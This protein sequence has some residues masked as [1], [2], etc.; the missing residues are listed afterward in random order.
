M[1][2]IMMAL[3]QMAGGGG[4]PAPG[5]A[6][7]GMPMGGGMPMMPPGPP[8][9]P[10][11]FIPGGRPPG[12]APGGAPPPVS[13][14]GDMTGDVVQDLII[15]AQSLLQMAVQQIQ[16]MD[17]S[18]QKADM[19][20]GILRDLSGVIA[21]DQGAPFGMGPSRTPSSNAPMSHPGMNRLAGPGRARSTSDL[22]D[23][24]PPPDSGM[25]MPL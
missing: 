8:P 7:P 20:S 17:P 14:G 9:G 12:P 23:V 16:V 4:G 2:P 18:S 19:L 1:D 3:Q 15:Q 25:E 13:P 10:P 24:P 5:G 21:N 6:P 11:P 22:P